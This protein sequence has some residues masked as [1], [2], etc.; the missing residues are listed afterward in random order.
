MY[1]TWSSMTLIQHVDVPGHCVFCPSS[2]LHHN[3]CLKHACLSQYQSIALRLRKY[4]QS[5]P[6][7]TIA[8][9]ILRSVLW[10][11]TDGFVRILECW[12]TRLPHPL[13]QHN[14]DVWVVSERFEIDCGPRM[15]GNTGQTVTRT[16]KEI[17]L[18]GFNNNNNSRIVYERAE[19][20]NS[21]VAH[22]RNSTTYRHK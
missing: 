8:I 20:T 1:N 19:S 14:R 13:S 11:G 3:C 22:Y 16:P 9:S 12:P 15:D 18:N 10:S 7:E 21:H 5:L 6:W 17:L 4:S 2:K